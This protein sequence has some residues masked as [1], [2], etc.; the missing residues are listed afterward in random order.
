MT[1]FLLSPAFTDTY[2]RLRYAHGM[3]LPLNFSS[4]AQELNVLS[5]LSILNFASGYRVPLHTATGRGAFDSI[6]ALVFSMY[7]SS[8]SDGDL[9]SASGMQS[10]QE[11]KIAEL[12]NVADKIHVE[13]P[14]K[15]LPAVMVGELGGPIWELVRLVAGALRET[16][17]VL[18]KGGYPN[19]GAFVLEALKEGEK[20]RQNGSQD[21]DVDPLCEVVLERVC[22]FFQFTFWPCRFWS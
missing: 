6:R 8:P 12:M 1:R 16:G 11:A 20:V 22:C 14:H 9:L 21:S 7:I 18:V 10:I 19:L 3:S 4:V 5:V 2:Q 15:D 17:D 13:R